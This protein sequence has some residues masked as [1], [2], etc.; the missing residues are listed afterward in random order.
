MEAELCGDDAAALPARS[1]VRGPPPQ[2]RRE[3]VGPAL[4]P[5]APTCRSNTIASRTPWKTIKKRIE[6]AL[7]CHRDEQ[8]RY[9]GQNLIK[10]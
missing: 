3:V 5:V 2:R 7:L 4:K 8:Q 6:D 1:L 9:S 10:N